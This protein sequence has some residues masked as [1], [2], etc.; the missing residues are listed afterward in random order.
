MKLFVFPPQEK[1]SGPP[2]I[3]FMNHHLLS[4]E[5]IWLEL[6]TMESPCAGTLNRANENGGKD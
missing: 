6:M 1:D 3:T 4:P 5:I 2:A